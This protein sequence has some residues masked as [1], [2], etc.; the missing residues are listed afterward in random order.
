[1]LEVVA[2]AVHKT[3]RIQVVQGAQEAVD[4]VIIM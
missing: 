2:E 4:L 3:A 1:M